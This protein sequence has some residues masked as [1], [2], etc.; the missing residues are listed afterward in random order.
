MTTTTPI[1]SA[2]VSSILAQAGQS[3]IAG[4][5]NS[6]LDVN[7]LVSTLV[8]SKT[9]GQAAILNGKLTADNAQL[10]AIG[11]LKSAMSALQTALTGLSN[12]S[13]LASLAATASGTGITTTIKSGAG[14][15]AGS[16]QVNVSQFASANKLTSAG[17]TSSDTISSG[18]LSITYGSNPAFNVNV[19]AGAA[20][21]D[22]AT[23]IN[24]ASGNPGVTAS[25]IT[26]SDGQHLVLQSNQTGAANA[27]AITGTGVNS[28]LTSGYATTTP[29]ADA[30]LTIDGTPVTSAS[31]SVSGA[32]T[33]V[34]LNLAP[35]TL[36]LNTP[37]TITLSQDTSA[38]TT[39][40]NNFANAYTSFVTTAKQLSS[41]DPTS[42][43]AGPLLGDSML[44]S[45]QNTLA[46]A[47]SSGVTTGGNTY[48]LASI[49]INLNADGSLKVDT[50]T[51]TTALASNSSAVSA[52]FNTTNGIG[53]TLSSTITN[54][55][56]TNGL[57]DQRTKAINADVTNLTNQQTQ[58][59]TYATQL[60]NQYNAQFTALNTLMAT[61]ANNTR[62]LTQLFG[63]Q[64]SAGAMATNK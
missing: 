43:N 16:Y 14:A 49:G 59:S 40:I 53:Q 10:T 4:S 56:K 2:N 9:A 3:L 17:L 36:A 44:N 1:T 54:Y 35:G 15:V 11:Q 7:S 21:S 34:T 23:S 42:S 30:K 48:S 38:M 32:L 60:T 24:S 19:S 31:N 57:I 39:A 8:Q 46:T 37:Q 41:Y 61:M 13:T 62:Y 51:L 27:I 28:K 55:T 20:L 5:T 26:G 58:L 33:G 12:G 45:I 63:G 64:N 18:S 25:V 50:A 6:T 52:I 22:I 47:L 29:A